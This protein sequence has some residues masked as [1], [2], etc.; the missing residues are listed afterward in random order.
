MLSDCRHPRFRNLN[1]TVPVDVARM[2]SYVDSLVNSTRVRVRVLVNKLN[3]IPEWIMPGL[4]GMFRNGW[5]FL[6]SWKPYIP[7]MLLNQLM[8]APFWNADFA[9]FTR[10][11]I[12]IHYTPSC[13][14]E[15]TGSLGRTKCDLG[16]VLDLKTDR[17]PCCCRQRPSGS[18]KPLMYGRTAVDLILVA[19]SLSDACRFLDFVV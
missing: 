16:V 11:L 19:G 9:T 6:S 8:R 1:S 13:F 7:I 14:H 5:S 4:I 18:D 2:K 17:M 10:N 12:V 15:S 3:F